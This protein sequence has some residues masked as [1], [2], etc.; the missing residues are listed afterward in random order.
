MKKVSFIYILP[1]LL[2]LIIAITVMVIMYSRQDQP[3]KS[4]E[5]VIKKEVQQESL[6]ETIPV[7][8]FFHDPDEEFLI[9]EKRNIYATNVLSDRA[10]QIIMELM[11]GAAMG[12]LATIP[13][14]VTLR[15]I[16]ILEDGT[17]FVDFSREFE[18]H[19]EGGSSNQLMQ[20]YSVVNS[21][22]FNFQE[23]EKVGIL[24]E[25]MQKDSFGGHIYS[26]GF[27]RE[28]LAVVKFSGLESSPKEEEI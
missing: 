4:V 13:E 25:G 20:I 16:Y 5:E 7:T 12:G 14:D 18:N 17:A 23:I 21:L 1:L 24:I 6:L 3:R 9:P 27:F 8:L 28:K 11:R 26:G 15:E 2:L 22:T 19:A 10:K